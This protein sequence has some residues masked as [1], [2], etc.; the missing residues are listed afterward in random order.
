ML[1]RD[2]LLAKQG[3]YSL[4]DSLYP[5]QISHIQAGKASSFVP[6]HGMQLY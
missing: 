1:L 6:F 4:H 5:R 3:Y 2:N